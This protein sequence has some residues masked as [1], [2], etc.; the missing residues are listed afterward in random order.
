VTRRRSRSALTGKRATVWIERN[1]AGIRI[2]DV[3]ASQAASVLADILEAMR[4]LATHYDELVA[5]LNPVP[6][7]TPV[8]GDASDFGAR[9]RR[10]GFIR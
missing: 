2:E 5:D 6:G 8:D 4:A 9:K 3:P 1:G 7:G 10:V